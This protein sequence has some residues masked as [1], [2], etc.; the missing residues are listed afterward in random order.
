M[1]LCKKCSKLKNLVNIFL[2]FTLC[3]NAFEGSLVWSLFQV[4]QDYIAS[5]FCVNQ[6]R[7]Q[8]MCHGKC[9]LSKQLKQSQEQ[10]ED[11]P[12]TIGEYPSGDHYTPLNINDLHSFL[13]HQKRT[14]IPYTNWLHSS[15]L[16]LGVFRPPP[17]FAQYF[18]FPSLFLCLRFSVLRLR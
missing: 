14:I 10:E 11:S 12:F 9:V 17:R 8:L 5:N 4:Q 16:L 7:P 1:Y 3:L 6:D 15:N 13:L 18:L 2:I